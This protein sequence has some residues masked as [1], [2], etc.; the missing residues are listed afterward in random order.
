MANMTVFGAQW[1]DEGK[2]K[3]VDLLGA[4]V[5]YIVRYQGGNNAGHTVIVDGEKY[6]LHIIPSGI[7][8][9]GKMCV[10]G[11]GVVLDPEVFFAELDGLATKNID[12]SPE[13]LIVSPKAHLIMP[14]HRL[15]DSAREGL[16]SAESRIGTTGRGIGPCYEDKM[17]RLGIRVGDLAE[18]GL[19]RRK[20][21]EALREKNVLLR[22]LYDVKPLDAD[23][24]YAQ[25]IA[26]APRI[27]PYLKDITTVLLSAFDAGQVA[28]FEGAQ[29]TM[30]DIDHGTYPY[31]TSSNTV[32]GNAGVGAGI[33]PSSITKQIAIVK[34]YTT[35]VG[36][37]PFPTELDGPV[38]IHL[39]NKGGEL[40]ATTGRI[41]RCGWFDAGIL[42]ESCRLCAPTSMALTKLDVLGGLDEI[43]I[44]VAY[45]YQ[46]QRILYPPQ[47]PNALSRVTPIY[48]SM[49]G[50][51]EDISA[52]Q[53]WEELPENARNYVE[54]IEELIGVRAEFVSVGPDRNQTIR[55]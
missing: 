20:I 3:I 42:R 25:T 9:A 31:V 52:C 10:I 40:G 38:G 24:V 12:I 7:L 17:A 6:V 21:E 2:G 4:E 29:G 46:G 41:R 35:R 53:T 34:A 19:L 8:H 51:Q 22:A 50:W 32:S 43:K 30:L 28:L 36:A 49:P 54:K 15:L 44:G 14:Y 18:P 48:E 33:P 23:E 1:G 39:Q 55:R 16:H 13:R 5:D 45:K 27:L 47:T 37:G 26:L 11:N